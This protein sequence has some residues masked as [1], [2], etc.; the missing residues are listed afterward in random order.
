MLFVGFIYGVLFI[1]NHAFPYS[2]YHQIFHRNQADSTQTGP[3]SIGIFEGNSPFDLHPANKANNPVL[4]AKNISDINAA[5]VA[6][7]F[8]IKSNDSF[9]MFFETKN[10]NSNKGV[11]AYAASNDGYHWSYRNVVIE[12]PFHLSYPNVFEW[13]GNYYII[14]ESNRDYS[15]RLYKAK[16]FPEKWEFST[17]LLAGNK[18]VDP[19]I[20]H[21]HNKWWL[22]VSSVDDD[23]LNI[24]YSDSLQNG[25]QPHP[26]N[27]VVKFNRHIARPGGRCFTFQNK[28]YRV[29]QDDDPDYGIQVFAI[30]ILELSDSTYKELPITSKPLVKFSGKGWNKA[31]MHHLDL[32]QLGNS[33]LSVAD[34]RC[35]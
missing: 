24:Y 16:H 6:D 7:P 1:R 17:T 29:A 27:P 4:S 30:E 26:L 23:V 13:N 31:G 12:E 20:L 5:F 9:Y 15:L 2:I 14:P 35:E 28:L 32:L 25:W 10:R 19:T 33:W 18:L 21:H 22:F 8:F 34:G 3:W 11:I